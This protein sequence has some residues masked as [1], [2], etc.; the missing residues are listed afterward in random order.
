MN[1][2]APSVLVTLGLLAL[3]LP[4][5]AQPDRR[6]YTPISEAPFPVV[7]VRP[8]QGGSVPVEAVQFMKVHNDARAVVGVP[9]LVWSPRL[10][11]YAQQWADRLAAEGGRTIR[12]RDQHT[13]GENLARGWGVDGARAAVLWL[14]EKKEYRGQPIDASDFARFGHYT[15]MV[16]RTTTH[17]G[18]GI[19][20]IGPSAIVVANYSPPGNMVGQ[21]PY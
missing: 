13:Y 14:D 15:Q 1:A 20:R 10:A 7:P 12:H 9:P 3:A 8:R 11:A 21:K 2:V 19:A 6:Y 16:W 18:F 4:G 17:V 5:T